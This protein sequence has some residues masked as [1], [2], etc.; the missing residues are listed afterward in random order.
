MQWLIVGAVLKSVA[1]RLPG[2]RIDQVHTSANGAGDGLKGVLILFDRIVG[3]IALHIVSG[4]G[5]S[6]EIR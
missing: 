4:R 5:A 3:A 1:D 6:I 2:L